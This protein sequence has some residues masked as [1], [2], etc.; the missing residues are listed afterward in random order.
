M[1]AAL[2]AAIFCSIRLADAASA[3]S[4]VPPSKGPLVQTANYTSFS[5][6]TQNDTTIVK[7]KVFDRIIQIWLENTDFET[8][9]ST[10]V[11][12]AIA[13]QGVLFTNYNAV[14]HP[15]EPNYVAAIGGDFFGMADDDMYHVPAN[16]SCIVDLLEDKDI[17]WATY[18]ENMPTDAFY[19]MIYKAPNYASPSSRPYPYYVRKHNPLMIFDAVSQDPS[20]INRIRTF[21]DFANDA[22]N[23]TLPQ[24]VFVTPNMVNDAH[25]TTIDF[26]ASFLEYWL[27]PL[28]IDPRVN[29][30]NTLILLT[31][32]ETESYG[33][34]NRIYTVA[35][36]QSNW[37]L[38]S[39]GRQD[40][41]PTV[42][43]VFAFVA[44]Q[45]GFQNTQVPVDQIPQFNLTGVA[46][47]APTSANFVPFVAPNLNARG[48]GSGGVFTGPGLDT[49]ITDDNLPPPVDLTALDTATPWQMSPRTSSGSM[50][51]PCGNAACA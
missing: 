51:I 38:K 44:E 30:E 25:D 28:I 36:V 8:A 5:N 10:S 11:F 45:T 3:Q 49:T 41:N 29:S 42:S 27:L 7:G 15:S 43:N 24:W 33:I 35:L 40:T 12:E 9:A 39:L 34:Q 47:G 1:T 19:G 17:S 21:N 26:A 18:Q 31:F 14:T 2:L 32:D 13:K 6:D 22:V 50:I 37:D 23:G 48:A 20:R 46:S 4:F 16:I